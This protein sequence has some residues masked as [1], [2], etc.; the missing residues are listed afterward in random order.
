M[1]KMLSS[2]L[3]L[4]MSAMMIQPVIHAEG[5]TITAQGYWGIKENGQGTG[6][7]FGDD[8]SSKEIPAEIVRDNYLWQ[9]D[10]D[11]VMNFIPQTMNG[12][13]ADEI[14][15]QQNPADNPWKDSDGNYLDIKKVIFPEGTVQV[16]GRLFEGCTTVKEATYPESC[17]NMMAAFAWASSF[18]KV[19][20]PKKLQLL[21]DTAF[22]GTAIESITLPATL[23]QVGLNTFAYAPNLKKVT[24][25]G[26]TIKTNAMVNCGSLEELNIYGNTTV[27][28]QAYIAPNSRLT[29]LRIG[30]NV[31]IA[32]GAIVYPLSYRDNKQYANSV[33]YGVKDTKAEA[34]AQKGFDIY[35]TKSQLVDGYYPTEKIKDS[36]DAVVPMNFSGIDAM[37]TAGELL[38]NISNMVLEISGNGEIPDYEEGTAPWTGYEAKIRTVILNDGVTKIGSNAFYGLTSLKNAEIASSVASIGNGAFA[39]C[40]KLAAVVIPDSVKKIGSA[41]FPES[42]S[43]CV[44]ASSVFANQDNYKTYTDG[45]SGD[46]VLASDNSVSWAVYGGDTLIISGNGTIIRFENNSYA[47]WSKYHKDLKTVVVEYGIKGLPLQLLGKDKVDPAIDTEKV[48]Y[49]AVKTVVIGDTV[50]LNRPGE[51]SGCTNIERYDVSY[52]CRQLNGYTLG[53]ISGQTNGQYVKEFFIPKNVKKDNSGPILC[54]M[55]SLEKL[56]FEEG[57]DGFATSNIGEWSTAYVRNAP[58]LKNIT[59]PYSVTQISDYSFIDLSGLEKLEILNPN[60][61]ISENAFYRCSADMTVICAKDSKAEI[62]AKSKNLKTETYIGSG[63]F[64]E[65]LSWYINGDGQMTVSGTGIMPDYSEADAAPWANYTSQIKT[66]LI[67]EGITTIGAYSFE[68]LSNVGTVTIPVSVTAIKDN[69]FVNCGE[70]LTIACQGGAAEEYANNNQIKVI[71][72]GTLS[73]GITWKIADKT[74]T[75]SGNGAI[76]GGNE[77][78]NAYLWDGASAETPWRNVKTYMNDVN[79]IIVEE[80]ITKI[81]AGAFA[82]CVGL[83]NIMLPKTLTTISNVMLH[84]A[85]NLEFLAIPENVTICGD[86]ISHPSDL[87]RVAVLSKT[88]D[89]KVSSLVS[90]NPRNDVTILCYEDSK[91]AQS[92]DIGNYN[93]ETIINHGEDGNIRWLV[94]S[95]G[96]LDIYGAGDLGTLEQAPWTEYAS[97][98][99][100]VYI[101]MGITGIGAGCFEGINNAYIEIP[102]TVSALQANAVSGSGCRVRVPFDVETIEENAFGTDTTIMSYEGTYAQEYAKTNNINFDL[103]KSLR[104][105]AIGNSY[106]QDTTDYLF[107]IAEASG[108]EDILIGNLFYP[109][110]NLK[111]AYEHIQNGDTDYT[112][113]EWTSGGRHKSWSG[114]SMKDGITAQKW[115]TITLQAWYPEAC[116]GL[117]GIAND[118]ETQWFTYVTNYIKENMTNKDAKLGFNMI[119]SMEATSSAKTTTESNPN[120]APNNGNTL[121]DW[122]RIVEQTKLHLAG[123]NNTNGYS[124]VLPVGT[125]IEN[126]RTSYLAG[127]RG[128]TNSNDI[129]G[130][131]QR[132]RVHLNDIGKYIA[133]I[134]WVKVL[135]PDWNTN[136]ITYMPNVKYKDASGNVTDESVFDED[137]VKTAK[138]AA[139]AAAANPYKITKSDSPYRII[140]YAD[141]KVNVAV[142]N[143]IRNGMSDVTRKNTKLVAAEYN[144]D[145]QLVS[146]KITDAALE[147]DE[148]V[149]SIEMSSGY[150]KNIF[151]I[152][153]FTA[154]EGNT[155]KLMLWDDF[156]TMTP[157]SNVYNK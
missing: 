43:A 142:S 37:G 45:V 36:E 27:E 82:L 28:K 21:S 18:E 106:T 138:A 59:I 84:E 80:G 119:W 14:G 140:R 114:K 95:E 94:T 7:I 125:A 10:S 33:I 9:L 2:I 151:D 96:S 146:C 22:A 69:A 50:P 34:F 51:I 68:G 127:I 71:I 122:N 44:S 81:P 70:G 74:L 30:E 40:E 8:E 24:V 29:T 120:N 55:P 5:A 52:A 38:W 23:N 153:D 67:Q 85:D 129:M 63:E 61:E 75:I 98:I 16:G 46:P 12:E 35:D 92:S 39:G 91:I 1:K 150:L 141:G 124:Y 155:V 83:E 101:H 53:T 19:N 76:P 149:G 139:A 157:I 104:L 148:T 73:N 115:D 79:T 49:P 48:Y 113:F 116:Y 117:D 132:D 15:N 107:Q 78:N 99:K 90:E 31:D 152:S 108:A 47:P 87:K 103:R 105:L 86:G 110:R 3:A 20:I 156:K 112:Y 41:A 130:G 89:K 77:S 66:V 154:D 72:G 97:S 60:T 26:G 134:T 118:D 102:H 126:A 42:A 58:K 144:S 6:S 25:N 121:N 13:E 4:C 54:G 123:D 17:T 143:E 57:F 128:T 135:E 147:Y 100:N 109:G 65:G 11:G 131:L 56:E 32:D 93:K 88:M 62:W 133:A 137:I 64:G 111:R 136:D 145:N